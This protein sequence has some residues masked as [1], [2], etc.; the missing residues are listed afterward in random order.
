VG[1]QHDHP[2]STHGN[3]RIIHPHPRIRTHVHTHSSAAAVG[4]LQPTLT[5]SPL[6]RL[7]CFYVPGTGLSGSRLPLWRLPLA[8][9]LDGVLRVLR[10]R[11]GRGCPQRVSRLGT[12]CHHACPVANP[13]PAP[14]TTTPTPTAQVTAIAPTR[15]TLHQP[16]DDGPPSMFHLQNV[17]EL[18][19]AGAHDIGRDVL[20][21][22]V[23]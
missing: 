18:C 1:D 12:G 13:L 3:L 9:H 7:H 20:H 10:G 17:A 16:A 2:S 23:A 14:S 22:L 21:K 6:T 5:H 8:N 11:A 15:Y 19:T 4:F